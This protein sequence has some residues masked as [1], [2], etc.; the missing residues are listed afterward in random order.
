MQACLPQWENLKFLVASGHTASQSWHQLQAVYGEDC[1][2]RSQVQVWHRCFAEGDGLT[3][4]TDLHRSGRPCSKRTPEAVEAVQ[5]AV[6]E[7]K[8]KTCAHIAEETGLS[9][10][11][12]HR[13]VRGELQMK[14]K[15]PKFVP[16]IL[17]DEQKQMR[18]KL[19][20]QNLALLADHP[21]LLEYIVTGDESSV[22]LYDPDTKFS[23]MHWLRAKEPRPQKALRAR[24]QTSTMLIT[25]FDSQGLLLKEFVPKGETVTG[26][27]YVQVL[28]R[29][30]DRVRRKW[31]NLW[32]T[33][34]DGEHHNFWLHHDNA[35]SHT[36]V[37]T[38]AFFGTHNLL[39]LPQPPYSPDLVPN[40]F[41]LFPTLKKQL[42]G[43]KH[44]N[45]AEVQAAVDKA[46]KNITP[47]MFR[48]ALLE[49]PRRWTK[50]LN[51]RGNYF[52]GWH[53]NGEEIAPEL[54]QELQQA[55]DDEDS[56]FP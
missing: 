15:A 27:F 13:I 47:D 20:S 45:V 36:C 26:E 25:F 34:R 19:C 12:V 55:Q 6:G 17:T 4:V 10:C 5:T 53:V 49:L 24:T 8:R 32:S 23:S 28:T 9:C 46:L 56:D 51:Q 21:D 41:F 2:S 44:R 37:E 42:W 39:L 3:P 11:T 52:K 14:K 43:K 35:S 31:P 40:D 54:A 30:Q 33:S 48:A 29:L 18:M 50:C 38:L 16:H 7:D 22:P 1:M